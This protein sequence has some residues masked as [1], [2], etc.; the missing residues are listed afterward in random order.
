MRAILSNQQADT[1]DKRSTPLEPKPSNASLMTEIESIIAEA[2]KLPLRDAAFSLWRQRPRLDTLEGPPMTPA[3][4][5]IAR[6]LSPEERSLKVRFNRDHAQDGATFDRLKR[7]YP[8]ASDTELK[9]A[10]IAAVRFD[11]ACFKYFTVDSTDYWQRV[12]RAVALAQRQENPGYLE[13][14]YQAAR[15][16]VAYYMK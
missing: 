11:D 5:G 12:V 7:A 6:A 9:L 13:G 10:I 8:Q 14:S 1:A 16:H 15:N 2:A 4:I 3:E